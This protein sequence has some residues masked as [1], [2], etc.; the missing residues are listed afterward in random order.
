[1]S[2]L[3]GI[4]DRGSEEQYLRMPSEARGLEGRHRV[5]KRRLGRARS[6]RAAVNG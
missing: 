2:Q 4:R 5:C 1:M 3:S 6:A